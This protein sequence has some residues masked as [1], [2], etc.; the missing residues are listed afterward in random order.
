MH[1]NVFLNLGVETHQNPL[2]A[3]D[4]TVTIETKTVVVGNRR[5]A[6][7]FEPANKW[8]ASHN[9]SYRHPKQVCRKTSVSY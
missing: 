4:T 5:Q 2:V 3:K 8:F 9:G 7:G 1:D 6:V